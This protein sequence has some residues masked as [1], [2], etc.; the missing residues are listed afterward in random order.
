MKKSPRVLEHFDSR[1]GTRYNKDG[2]MMDVDTF[3]VYI[4][5]AYCMRKPHTFASGSRSRRLSVN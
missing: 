2:E 4:M 3:S 1:F 5:F